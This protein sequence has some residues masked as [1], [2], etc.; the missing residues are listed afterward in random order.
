MYYFTLRSKTQRR[1]TEWLAVAQR[2][3]QQ[4]VRHVWSIGV[5]SLLLEE[6]CEHRWLENTSKKCQKRQFFMKFHQISLKS[7]CFFLQYYAWLERVTSQFIWLQGIW[8]THFSPVLGVFFSCNTLSLTHSDMASFWIIW[9]CIFFTLF[10]LSLCIFPQCGPTLGY[11]TMG[12]RLR[13]LSL[14]NHSQCSPPLGRV[15]FCQKHPNMMVLLQ[16]RDH[17]KIDTFVT[18]LLKSGLR[19]AL[20]PSEI[21]FS[22]IFG[23][24]PCF[25][26]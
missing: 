12:I 15:S 13:Y 17:F 25:L 3:D 23:F 14:G 11:I 5:S 22:R 8:V 1:S 4:K 21:V 26:L 24:W 7:L 9:P 6:I 20:G 16:F 10:S 19:F 18:L 2:Q